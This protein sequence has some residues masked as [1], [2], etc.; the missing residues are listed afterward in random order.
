MRVGKAHGLAAS[1]WSD[2]QC[3]ALWGVHHRGGVNAWAFVMEK[4][5]LGRKEQRKTGTWRKEGTM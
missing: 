1:A 3:G 5:V 4:A 2:I